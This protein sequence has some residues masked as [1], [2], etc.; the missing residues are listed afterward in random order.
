MEKEN[1]SDDQILTA[2]LNPELPFENIESSQKSLNQTKLDTEI[3]EAL[4]D[5]IKLKSY[6]NLQALAIKGITF[7]GDSLNMTLTFRY[8]STTV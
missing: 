2:I 4:F 5:Q 7:T 3:Q 1:N 6:K 8:K